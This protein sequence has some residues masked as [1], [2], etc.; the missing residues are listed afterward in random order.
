MTSSHRS[1]ITGDVEDLGEID[2]AQAIKDL[3]LNQIGNFE[4]VALGIPRE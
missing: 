4:V 3:E 2:T 1:C